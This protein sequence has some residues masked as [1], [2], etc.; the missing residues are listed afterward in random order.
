MTHLV[1]VYSETCAELHDRKDILEQLD[2][3]N[4]QNCLCEYSKYMMNINLNVCDRNPSGRSR[5]KQLYNKD[6][7]L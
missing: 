3:H 2:Y 1:Q 7:E 4:I 6:F 5:T